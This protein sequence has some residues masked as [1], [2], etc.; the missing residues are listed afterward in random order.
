MDIILDTTELDDMVKDGCQLCTEIKSLVVLLKVR[1]KKQSGDYMRVLEQSRSF[2][3]PQYKL[4]SWLQRELAS[5]RKKAI[6]AQRKWRL[7][8]WKLTFASA[9][10]TLYQVSIRV[11]HTLAAYGWKT[12]S[13]FRTRGTKHK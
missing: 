2:A 1:V 12:R 3:P 10:H 5:L 7:L 4:L 9:V 6:G 8:R 11:K 13:L